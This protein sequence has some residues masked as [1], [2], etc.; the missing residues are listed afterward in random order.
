MLNKK[1]R[2]AV[3][4]C[5]RISGRHFDA[6]IEA[7]EAE[8]VAT[9]D[10]IEERVKEKA[11]KYGL[12]KWYTDYVEMFEKENID[13]VSICTPSGLHC[14]NTVKAA[15]YGINV[16]CEKPIGITKTQLDIMIKACRE[17]KVKF[18]GI[19]QRRTCSAPLYTIDAVKAGKLGKLVLCSASLKYYRSQEY[20]DSGEWRGTWELDGGGALMNQGIHGIDMLQMIAG[21]I[22]SVKAECKTLSRNIQVED[23]SVIIVKFKHGGLGVIEGT[24]SV[25]PGQETLFSLHG[26]KGTITFGD[27]C[28]YRWKIMD[29]EEEAPEI[30]DSMGGINCGWAAG[31]TGHTKQV[32]DIAN[33][34]FEDRDPMIPG[35]EARKAVDVILAIYESSKTG[36]EIKIKS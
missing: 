36:K 26:D 6:I 22:E 19:F 25:W 29:S 30:N 10:I 21:D 4:G 20:Y 13:V 1:L 34:V 3:L 28:F 14:E 18:G 33:A 24:T 8:L 31:N 2:F 27:N 23:T 17:A 7:P 35:E 12:D 16:L 5:G 15:E 9:C 11:S 32:R